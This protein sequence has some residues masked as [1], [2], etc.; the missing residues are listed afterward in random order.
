MEDEK[1]ATAD[2]FRSAWVADFPSPENF[3]WIMYGA[4][5]PKELDK[6]SYPNTVRY[7]NKEYDKLFDAG[8]AAKTEEES[9]E[10]FIKAEQLM[11][12]DAPIMVLWYDAD[13][14]LIKSNVR[15]YFSN[16]IG[17]YN[18]SEVYLKAVESKVDKAEV[19]Q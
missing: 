17:Y 13:Y 6:P 11:M 7:V 5:V 19:N 15:N 3:L 10:N 9:F 2:M 4:N 16:S 8:K 14:R 12:D 18:F 1:Y